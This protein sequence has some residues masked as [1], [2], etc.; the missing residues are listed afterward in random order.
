MRKAISL[1]IA[2]ILAIVCA[3]S[4]EAQTVGQSTNGNYS[5]TYT[6]PGWG[7]T[8]SN[9]WGTQSGNIGQAGWQYNHAPQANQPAGNGT[10]PN[11][12]NRPFGSSSERDPLTTRG[13]RF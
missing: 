5:N 7:Q 6:A 10:Y 13:R 2:G 4:G 12:T 3:S 1:V 11:V 9:T 8:G